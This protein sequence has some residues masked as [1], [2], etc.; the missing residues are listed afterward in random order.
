MRLVLVVV[1]SFSYH[2][3]LIKIDMNTQIDVEA[4]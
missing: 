3:Y 1:A 2:M 4:I